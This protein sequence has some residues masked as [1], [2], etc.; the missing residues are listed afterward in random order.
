MARKKSDGNGSTIE[1]PVPVDDPQPETR[2]VE[3]R[4]N[5]PVHTVRFGAVRAS[6][7][8]NEVDGRTYYNVTTSRLYKG[9]DGTWYA[10][11]S[12]GFNN[13]LALA[14]C[15]D[16]AHSYIAARLAEAQGRD[17]DDEDTPF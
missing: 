13:L 17:Q 6:I 4:P 7:W 2:N 1:A 12:F 3:E 9:A 5:T 10:T 15:L 8:L 14:K 16:W 11:H